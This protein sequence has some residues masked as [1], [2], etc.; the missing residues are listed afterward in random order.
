MAQHPKPESLST[1]LATFPQT[2]EPTKQ[3]AATLIN[4]IQQAQ[5]LLKQFLDAD[6]AAYTSSSSASTISISS[7]SPSSLPTQFKYIERTFGASNRDLVKYHFEQMQMVLGYWKDYLESLNTFLSFGV[8]GKIIISE[9]LDKFKHGASTNGRGKK[10][11]L[12]IPQAMAQVN[13]LNIITLIHEASHAAED[14]HL[15]DICLASATQGRPHSC[16]QLLRAERFCHVV[17]CAE[18]EEQNFVRDVA[19]GAQD[20]NR[21]GRRLGF[22]FLTDVTA[23]QFG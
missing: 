12:N 16:E 10:A 21:H 8:S 18:F 1:V 6:A 7:S 4:L 20:D 17:I 19:G 9:W 11:V 13:N 23:R 2:R 15:T 3:E 22:D 14:E 5:L